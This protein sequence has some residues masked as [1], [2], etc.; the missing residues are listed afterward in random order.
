[1]GNGVSGEE[2][3]PLLLSSERPVLRSLFNWVNEGSHAVF[4]DVHYSPG[5]I[6]KQAYLGVFW[7]VFEDAGQEAHY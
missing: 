4:E 1:M 5:L 6:S 3:A 7:R 2:L